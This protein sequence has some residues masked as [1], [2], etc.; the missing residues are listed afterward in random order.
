MQTYRAQLA[1]L[2]RAEH[3]SVLRTGGRV[4]SKC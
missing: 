2:A 3:V 4:A 1:G